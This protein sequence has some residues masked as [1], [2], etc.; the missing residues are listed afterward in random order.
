MRRLDTV[1]YSAMMRQVEQ[2][3]V[4]VDTD[5]D[6]MFADLGHQCENEAMS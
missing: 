1:N 4:R 2:E 3:V 5:I 6:D